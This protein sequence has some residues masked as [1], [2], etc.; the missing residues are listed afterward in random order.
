M[1]LLIDCV[2]ALKSDS[3]IAGRDDHKVI[4][5]YQCEEVRL[6]PVS[7]SG[8][9]FNQVREIERLK[10]QQSQRKGGSKSEG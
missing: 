1:T 3:G 10:K 9:C 6:A 8:L 7:L 4:G 2:R 5:V